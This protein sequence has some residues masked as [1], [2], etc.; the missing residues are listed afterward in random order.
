MTTASR[1]F[2]RSGVILAAT[3]ALPLL[4][5]PSA[6]AASKVCEGGQLS[7]N[8]VT[9][10]GV[11]ADQKI[12][13][14]VH[15]HDFRGLVLSVVDVRFDKTLWKGIVAPG[16]SKTTSTDVFGEPP[17]SYKIAFRVDSNASNNYTYAISSRRCY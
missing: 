12:N 17:I 3:A 7:G 1:R 4:L 13:I 11:L 6:S 8:K 9:T 10:V 2:T 14:K 16:K 5:A 15:N